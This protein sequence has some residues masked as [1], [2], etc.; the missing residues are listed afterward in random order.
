[1]QDGED[2]QDR[3]YTVLPALVG[4]ITRGLQG[5]R[6]RGGLCESQYMWWH[7]AEGFSGRLWVE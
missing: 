6:G 5:I 2:R 1:M 7:H 3:L 4:G